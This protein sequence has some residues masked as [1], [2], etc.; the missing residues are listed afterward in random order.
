MVWGVKAFYYDKF[1]STDET[2]MDLKH[3]LKKHEYLKSGD[4][5]LNAASMP[6]NERQRTNTLKISK[7]K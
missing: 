1:S 5:V 2:I 3:L 7:I 6:I 4:I